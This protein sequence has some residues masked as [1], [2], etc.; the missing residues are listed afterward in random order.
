MIKNISRNATTYLYLHLKD[1]KAVQL[2][3]DTK[4]GIAKEDTTKF[5]DI[6]VIFESNT[7]YIQVPCEPILVKKFIRKTSDQIRLSD[8]D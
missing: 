2:S 3:Q 5:K 8:K 7:Q 4:Y 6:D 1:M